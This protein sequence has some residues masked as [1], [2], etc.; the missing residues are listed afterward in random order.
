[1]HVMPAIFLVISVI[2]DGL[3]V[4]DAGTVTAHNDTICVQ[5]PERHA[6]HLDANIRRSARL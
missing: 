6:D 5:V 3:V 4:R 1:M 2:L